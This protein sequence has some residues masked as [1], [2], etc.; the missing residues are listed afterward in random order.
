MIWTLAQILLFI[1]SLRCLLAWLNMARA[2][3][4]AKHCSPQAILVLGGDESREELSTLL[5]APSSTQ[6]QDI[7]HP[8]CGPGP[9]L[10]GAPLAAHLGLS[11][12]LAAVF[13]DPTIPIYISSPGSDICC[14]MLRIGVPAARI[15]LDDKAVDTVTNFTTMLPAL[16]KNHI[17]HVLAVTSDYHQARAGWIGVLVLGGSGIG[18]TMCG[19]PTIPSSNSGCSA[20]ATASES[21]RRCTR[22]TCRCVIWLLTGVHFGFVGRLVHPERFRHLSLWDFKQL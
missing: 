11:Q 10:Q 2:W 13:Q 15:N 17:R 18:V 7:K 22:D 12:G 8:P 1:G 21:L 6:L 4:T 16:H 20:H 5:A 14:A 19:L 3:H 9:Q